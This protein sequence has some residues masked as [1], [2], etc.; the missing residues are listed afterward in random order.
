MRHVDLEKLA[1]NQADTT[2]VRD[3]PDERRVVRISPSGKIAVTISEQSSNV[4]F[5]DT[6]TGK[7][8]AR[9]DIK[10]S[11][12]N[13]DIAFS[14]DEDQVAFCYE[15][16]TIC[17][18]MHPEKR[19]SFDFW[20]IEDVSF[21][22]VAFQ[23]CNDLVICAIFYDG[24]GARGNSDGESGVLQVWHRQDPTGFECTYS[25]DI[26]KDP[27]AILAPDGLT[28]II[29]P[30]YSRYPHSAKCYSWNHNTAQFDLVHF[31]DQVHID[32]KGE[33]DD[34]SPVYSPDGKLFACWSDEDSHVRVWD[35]R[36]GHLVSKFPTFWVDRIALSPALIDHS[37]GERLIALSFILD[38]VIR[39]FDAYTGHP[40]AQILGETYKC[41]E[42]LR[43]G[44][45]LASYYHNYG[46][47]KWEIA[48]FTAE[49]RHSTDGYELRLQGVKNGWM[50][51]QDDE[52]LFWVPVENRQGLYVPAPRVLIEGS[53]ISTILDFSKSRFGTKWTECI[54]K[55][56][57]RELEQ[58]EKEVGNLLE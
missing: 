51:D 31:D 26:G 7:V 58:K 45:A 37:L 39:L 54:D 21:G 12:I 32:W 55:G 10:A 56:W 5:L 25:L 50:V 40:R 24:S 20:P 22:K 35:T 11:K 49:H 30:F 15:S 43:D 52:P 8:V 3:D 14:P 41:M 42:F 19:V 2:Y 28:V 13:T 23:T 38:D 6:T 9:A 4:R 27:R 34:Y 53:E 36:T 16:L 46:V 29:V 17:D 33:S 18:I 47:R 1:M 48:D 57:L 44:T